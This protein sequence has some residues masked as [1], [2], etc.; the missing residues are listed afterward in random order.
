MAVVPLK[1]PLIQAVSKGCNGSICVGRALQGGGRPA[2]GH[3]RP[4]E[5]VVQFG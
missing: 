5:V 2:F 4:V 3:H 1:L